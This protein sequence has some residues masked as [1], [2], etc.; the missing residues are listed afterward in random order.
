[1]GLWQR[2]GKQDLEEALRKACHPYGGISNNSFARL[3]NHAPT[4][5]FAGDVLIRY[6]WFAANRKIQTAPAAPISVYLQDLKHHM[7]GQIK[8]L[9]NNG[10]SNDQDARQDWIQ[11]ED[12]REEEQGSLQIHVLCVPPKDMAPMMD[13]VS[14][15]GGNNARKKRKRSRPKS[16][17]TQGGDPRMNLEVRLQSEGYDWI[18]QSTAENVAPP[19]STDAALAQYLVNSN[20]PLEYH[21]AVF[22]RPIFL[23]GFYTKSR[24]DVSQTPFLVMNEGTDPD[25]N[26]KVMERKGVTSV[27]EQI[28]GPIEK[29]L[30]IS[31]LNNLPPPP[32]RAPASNC[33]R[34]DD[35][36][37]VGDQNVASDTNSNL[38][39]K[40]GSTQ[41]GGTIYGMIKFH[42]SGR[43]DMDVRMLVRTDSETCRGRPFCVQV[44]DALR[45]L[46]S[47]QQLTELVD[48]INHHVAFQSDA[49]SKH[50]IDIGKAKD[51]NTS[52]YGQNPLGVGISPDEFKVVSS[53]VFSS[54]QQDTESKVKHYGCYC[55]SSK[56]LGQQADGNN[57]ISALIFG[58]TQFPL[59]IHQ[60]T[61]VRVLHR[62]A[63]LTRERQILRAKAT[64]IDGHHFRLELSTSAGTYVKE[65]VYGDLGRSMPSVSSLVGCK[66]NLLRLDCEGIEMPE[67]KE[68]S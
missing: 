51:A 40:N 10:S 12:I 54:L 17:T 61:P 48:T 7:H 28:C 35:E 68:E 65:F 15:E 56:V 13:H 36:T 31:T 45:S 57:D 34:F 50:V 53:K 64:R 62:R 47:A 26:K 3:P 18:S 22:R 66:T 59:T 43:E 21:L 52:A 58:D 23:Y 27:E 24:R 42:A 8:D 39:N 44:V 55:W 16:Y 41:G 60:K 46:T 2:K 30:G 38:A 20:K 4:A 9:L 5:S 49:N 1:M 33:R 11:N 37:D 6:K 29:M 63:N 14:S 19:Q 67:E 32:P 25:K